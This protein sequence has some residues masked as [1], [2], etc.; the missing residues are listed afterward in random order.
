MVK[1]PEQDNIPTP[2]Q[3]TDMP[4]MPPEPPASSLSPVTWRYIGLAV[5]AAAIAVVAIWNVYG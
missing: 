5:L 4:P 2:G 3:G 1:V